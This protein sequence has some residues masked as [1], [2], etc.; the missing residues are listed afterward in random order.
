VGLQCGGHYRYDDRRIHVDSQSSINVVIE[1]IKV[2]GVNKDISPRGVDAGGNRLLVN[3]ATDAMNA[4]YRTSETGD[5]EAVLN[6]PGTI[7][8]DPGLPSGT[9][10]VIGTFSDIQRARIIFFN[11]NSNGNHGI[12]T[13]NPETHAFTTL[14]QK[15]FL[16]F[17]INTRY[18]ITGVGIAQDL[19]YW[20]DGTN[21]DR[22]INMTRDYTSVTD[23]ACINLYKRP[24]VDGVRYNGTSV[25]INSDFSTGWTNGGPTDDGL[26]GDP[27]IDWTL[28]GSGYVELDADD[29]SRIAR[30]SNTILPSKTYT[31]Q[32]DI[33][34]AGGS[35]QAKITL[36]WLDASDAV[37]DSIEITGTGTVVTTVTSPETAVRIGFIAEA[38]GFSCQVTLDNL[39]LTIEG[40]LINNTDYKTSAIAG[41]IYQFSSRYIYKDNEPSAIGMYTSWISTISSDTLTSY[42]YNGMRLSLYYQPELG[43]V[44]SKVQLLYRKNNSANWYLYTEKKVSDFGVA[45]SVT[46]DFFDD[47][48]T[49]VLPD[50]EVNKL[51]DS[52]PHK[53][54]ALSTFKNRN[55]VSADIEDYE[56]DQNQGFTV[57]KDSADSFQVIKEGGNYSVGPCYYDEDFKTPGVAYFKKVSVD[58]QVGTVNGVD[59]TLRKVLGITISDNNHPSWAKYVT[60]CVSK[61]QNYDS[62]MQIPTKVMFYVGEGGLLNDAG[63]AIAIP[64][65]MQLYNNQKVYLTSLPNNSSIKFTHLHWQVPESIP[66]VPDRDCFLRVIS[67]LTGLNNSATIPVL[68]FDGHSIITDN[69]DSLNWSSSGFTS[70][71]YLIIEV[72]KIKPV[73]SKLFYELSNFKLTLPVTLAPSFTSYDGIKAN[74]AFVNNDIN[75]KAKFKFKNMKIDTKVSDA[76]Y[77]VSSLFA[78]IFF[79]TPS[80]VLNNSPSVEMDERFMA[81]NYDSPN[82]ATPAPVP[83]Y[84]RIPEFEG[85]AIAYNPNAK[86][87]TR[88]T[89]IRF[90][91]PYI[92]DS[93]VNGL[94]SFI[95]NNEYALPT[96][97][98]PLMKLQP[99][100]NVLLAI[101]ERSCTSLYVEE[102][103]ITNT[104]GNVTAA[105]TDKV[106]GDDRQ[107]SPGYGSYHPESIVEIN[108]NVFGFD[109]FQ[110]VVWR[111][112]N[113]GMVAISDVGMR[114]YFK[115]KAEQY[116]PYKDTVAILGGIDPFNKEFLLTFPAIEGVDAVTWAFNFED[117]IWVC[118]YSFVPDAY[119]HLNNFLITFKAGKAWVHNV[120]FDNYNRFY[121]IRYTRSITVAINPENTHSKNW[122]AIQI[123][124]QELCEGDSYTTTSAHANFAAF[125]GTGVI[126][127]KYIANDTLKEFRWDGSAYQDIGETVILVA[128]NR[129]GQSTYTKRKDFEK[130]E[131]I[132]YGP[133][134][135]DL[136]TPTDLMGAGQLKLRDG[137]D[138][139]SQVLELTINNNSY[140][141][142]KMYYMNVSF[143]HSKYSF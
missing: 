143:A 8:Y 19:L 133:I 111:Y 56:V 48:A 18:R 86:Q 137:R 107:L 101:H 141:P 103:L 26:G 106:I 43:P 102:S 108:G 112:S 68:E 70:S 89:T 83:D 134:L 135:K 122:M 80:F 129:E 131:G 121:D 22:M 36:V 23:A 10:T 2:R 105:K 138:M 118:R 44:I 100:G 119:A 46:I 3:P 85:R 9:N 20:S 49:I 74:D 114:T 1:R 79:E 98:T 127:T 94:S 123:S 29:L 92:Q 69:I 7:G 97:R 13:F 78:T 59:L 50:I 66:F 60:F 72:F 75:I 120:D 14:I 30:F 25:V 52:V 55:F 54:K 96:F 37:V 42:T 34:K 27:Y 91:L 15:A 115:T 6:I 76:C 142:A 39:I 63:S 4:R 21:P 40:F 65:G 47:N 73:Q 130:K 38:M 61:D 24:P 64:G 140:G 16:N 53:S 28:S 45:S 139:I 93:N 32:L 5:M 71:N 126:G 104:D 82:N 67:P 136:N 57:T 116:L 90:S 99:V 128:T 132:F 58:Y 17:S 95:Y 31:L 113:N 87:I 33:T 11:Y 41:N 125:P 88:D 35:P 117:N 81:K 109:I 124:A 77:N 110:G 12:Y 62:Y 84:R 51:F